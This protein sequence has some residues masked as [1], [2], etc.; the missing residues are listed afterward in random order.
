MS[1]SDVISQLTIW[2]DTL[3]S[4]NVSMADVASR[5][6]DGARDPS[7]AMRHSKVSIPETSSNV[8]LLWCEN[9]W[10]EKR[11]G[12]KVYVLRQPLNKNQQ[13]SQ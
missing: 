4:A 11:R 10:K 1:G 12:K 6:N 8:A 5:L 13:V 7:S 2:G 3:R 9:Q